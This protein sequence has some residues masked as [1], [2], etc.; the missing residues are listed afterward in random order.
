LQSIPLTIFEDLENPDPA[1]HAQAWAAALVLVTFVLV[2]SILSKAALERSRRK[3][4]R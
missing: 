4:T 3:L 1:L 2:I